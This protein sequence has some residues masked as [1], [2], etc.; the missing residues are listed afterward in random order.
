MRISRS[1]TGSDESL[2]F[3]DPKAAEQKFLN[4]TMALA[5]ITDEHPLA[6]FASPLDQKDLEQTTLWNRVVMGVQATQAAYRAYAEARHDRG[7]SPSQRDEA[8]TTCGAARRRLLLG[9]AELERVKLP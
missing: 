9:V 4:W 7:H 6:L 1:G 3:S 5:C 2:T 8:G